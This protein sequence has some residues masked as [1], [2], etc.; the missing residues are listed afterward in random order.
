MRIKRYGWLVVVFLLAGCACDHHELLYTPKPAFY[1]YVMG[2]IDDGRIVAEHAAD[3]YTTPASCQKVITALLAY[4]TL[5][6]EFRFETKAYVT[7]RKN[8]IQSVI[9]LPS[10]D[11]TLTSRKLK[12]LLEPLQGKLINENIVIETGL[13]HTPEYSK[14]IMLNDVGTSYAPPVSSLSLDQNII[15]ITVLPTQVGAKALIENDA[16][17][18]VENAITTGLD[19]SS[20]KL[21]WEG[22]YIR[23]TGCV[24]LGEAPLVLKISPT[25]TR[26][27]ITQKMKRILQDL[28]IK[29]K[30]IFASEAL[31]TRL[32][33][34]L[35]TSVVSEPLDKIIPPALKKSDNHIFDCLYLKLIHD[36]DPL[37]IKD[38]NDGDKVIKALIK[39]HFHIDMQKA[40]LVDGSGLSRYNRLQPR[41]L[42]E[43]LRRGYTT[44]EFVAALPAPGELNSTL[45]QRKTLPTDVKAKTGTLSGISCLCGYRISDDNPKAFVIMANSFPPPVSELSSVIDNFLMHYLE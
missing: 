19:P 1:S 11:P 6:P 39:E 18:I 44:K 21:S 2:S 40:L 41:Q 29:G 38:W 34:Q 31:N 28:K 27:Y 10:G 17:Y 7:K 30:I 32:S 22:D 43:I 15:S 36:R 14:N 42:F 12:E 25:E 24:K 33:N 8:S 4:K 13:F 26:V 16:G 5:G 9:I 23:A 37:A 3:V 45:A 35:L 20:V